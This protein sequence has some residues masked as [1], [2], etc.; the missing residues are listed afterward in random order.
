MHVYIKQHI[1]N[2]KQP[3]H[4]R[5]IN[6]CDADQF[7]CRAGDCKYSDNHNCN[8]PCIRRDWVN[9]GEADC[10]DASDEGEFTTNERLV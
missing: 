2:S 1:S 8:G 4:A 7:Q 5:Q 9:D 3:R 6:F 10:T